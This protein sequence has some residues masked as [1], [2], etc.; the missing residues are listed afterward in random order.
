MDKTTKQQDLWVC[1]VRSQLTKQC[2]IILFIDPAVE[3]IRGRGASHEADA[4]HIYTSRNPAPR[5]RI[6]VV[7]KANC[8]P[9]F[10]CKSGPSSSFHKDAS[11][12]AFRASRLRQ[13]STS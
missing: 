3:T 13:T 1:G 6:I 11:N 7:A 9:D 5:S 2:L 8:V 10:M 4:V 12:R